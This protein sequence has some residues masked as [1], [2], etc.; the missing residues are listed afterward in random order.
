MKVQLT[1]PTILTDIALALQARGGSANLIGGSVRDFF[2]GLTCKD[3]DVEVFGL[4]AQDVL[5][6][7]RGFGKVELVGEKI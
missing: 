2:L 6:I 1:F 4:D 3:F 5:A 7:L